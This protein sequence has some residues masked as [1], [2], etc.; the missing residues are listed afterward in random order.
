ML[1]T[2][3]F[4]SDRYEV[5]SKVGAGGMSDVYKAKDHILGRFVA[6]KVLKPE[7]AE[8]RSFVSK[9]KTEA[10]SAAG[11]E[12]PNI[13]NIYDVGND[14]NMYFIVMEYV[15]GITLKTYIEKKGQL[16]FK[17]SA[18]IAIQVARGIESAHN[19]EIIHRDIKPQN[20]IIS[21]E[22]KVKVTDF[23]IAKAVSS[24]TISSDV[25]GS[26]HYVSPEQARN[27]YVD[28]RSDLYSLG[29]V[30]FEMITGRVPF[31]GDTTVAVAI[32]HL[33]EE[34]PLPSSYASNI[35]ISFEKIILK[36]TQKNADRRY[37]TISEL[38]SDL[39]RSLTN[40]N[41][42]F[43]EIAPLFDAGKTRII[44]ANELDAIKSK[45]V[46]T[47]DIATNVAS[48][49]K[50]KK[51][52]ITEIMNGGGKNMDEDVDDEYYDD[53]DD[54]EGY[55][56]PKL[57]KAVT[58]AGIAAAIVIVIFIIYVLGAFFDFWKFGIGNRKDTESQATES[59]IED[60]ESAMVEMINIINKP[61]DEAKTMLEQIGLDVFVISIEESD[62]PE[63]TVIYQDIEEGKSI[64]KGT[65]INVKVAG[66]K[67]DEL[68]DLV[69]VPNLVGKTESD[70]I[71]ELELNQLAYR[72]EYQYSDEVPADVV[73][74]QTPNQGDVA[75]GSTIV[76]IVSQ[77]EESVVV[78]LVINETQ[79]S[80][81]S[82]LEIAGLICEV[83]TEYS[84][85][86]EVGYVI[87]QSV[88]AGSM[89]PK[90]SK[91]K[92]IVSLGKKVVYYKVDKSY[93]Y[94]GSND[95]I[96]YSWTLTGSDG[97]VIGSGEG[98]GPTFTV[99]EADIACESGKIEITWLYSQVD[100]EGN[101]LEEPGRET[102]NSK[103]KFEKQ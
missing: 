7:F 89:V 49:A 96:G 81:Q 18:S 30:M 23:G 92:I 66:E 15:E 67:E 32:Q 93:S 6:I 80:A 100:E 47:D 11:L 14:D 99:N 8:D 45:K 13:V 9:F 82:K 60:S 64:Q 65:T 97:N 53:E 28:C 4:I 76:I 2:G 63:G 35:P 85:S 37:Q 3:M 51:N 41:E 56:N 79:N 73:I 16:S 52:A 34:M 88:D 39:R 25:M 43:V 70:A 75:P 72:K 1:E 55:L 48:A 44:N 103:V 46:N 62:L 77:G 87:N 50:P 42:D 19:K 33:Q 54:D 94:S 74:S 61:F 10:Q 98:D 12:H 102:V 5:L 69:P 17:E 57:D 27:G 29:I 26:V 86:V 20:I 40:P 95:V 101:E 90:G 36:C 78:P 21:T 71:S 84:D 31:D 58:I 59:Q 83:G 22:G 38:I 68:A 91:V 24:N